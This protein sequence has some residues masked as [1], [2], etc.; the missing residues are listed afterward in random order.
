MKN[1]LP[2]I[3]SLFLLV[4]FSC[5]K[6]EHRIFYEGGTAPVLSASVNGSIPLSFANKDQEAVKFSWT[7]PGYQFTTGISSQDVSY[8][9]EIDTT[10]SNF[11]NPQKQTVSVSKDLSK[12]FTQSAFNDFLLNQLVLAPGMPHNIEVRL[13]SSLVGGNASLTSNVLKFT[14]TPYSIPPKV[15][16]P[17]SGTLYITGSATPGNW[18]GGGDP[19]LVSQKFTRLSNTLYEITIALTGGN[20]YTFVPVYGDWSNKYSIAV[21]NDPNEVNGGDFQV[22]GQDILAPAASG[23]YKIQV[24][25]QRGKFTVTKL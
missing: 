6:D 1:R 12:S 19:E 9:L 3:L 14:A 21:K 17:A 22:G 10:G 11:S 7:N 25:F 13:K 5:K 4:L 2:I 8:L 20:S 23:N 16:P 18:M 15:A 24:D